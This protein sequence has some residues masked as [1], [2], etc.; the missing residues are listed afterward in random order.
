MASCLAV[1]LVPADPLFAAW[2][3]A[4][5]APAAVLYWGRNG[6]VEATNTTGIAAVENCRK[7]ADEPPIASSDF[8]GI[9]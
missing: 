1:G 4:Q 2:G 5:T 8:P 7:E 9:S 6:Q 3:L